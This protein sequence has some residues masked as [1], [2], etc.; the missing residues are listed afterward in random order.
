MKKDIV[1]IGAGAAGLICAYKLAKNTN[2]NI[3]VIEKES[4]PGK[5]LKAA[6]S[7]KCNIT[8]DLYSDT[9]Y[10]SKELELLKPYILKH[11]KQD[12]LDLFDELMLPYYEQ[13]GYYYPISN[14]GK[15]V[16]STL[17]NRCLEL[18]VQFSF[19]TLALKIQLENDQYLIKCQ[20]KDNSFDVQCEYLVCAMGGA[21]SKQLGGTDKGYKLLNDIGYSY[22]D[23]LPALAPIY[24]KDSNLKL[25]KG[26]RVNGT[27]SIKNS[28]DESIK[29]AGQIQFNEDCISGICVM[30]LSGTMNTWLK[31]NI[32]KEM[33]LDIVPQYS[34]NEL[35]N[36]F[37]AYQKSYKNEKMLDCLNT[38]LPNG[39]SKYILARIKI[40]DEQLLGELTDKTIN[41]LTSTLKKLELEVIYKEEFNKAQV[42]QGGICLNQ[43]S[44]E[45][46]ESKKH[47]KLYILGEL[48]DVNGDCGGYNITFAFLSAID[49]A[50]HVALH[51]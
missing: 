33:F 39:I 42:S 43:I 3:I 7:G 22:T 1:I 14:Q 32:Y 48:L 11:S 47:P 9:V 24:V 2:K 49:A 17:Y 31:E 45:T 16:V 51:N 37:I 21:A 15:Q 19:S 13:N 5:K 50:K 26:V 35:K 29:E 27:I 25:A 4:L 40:K 44:L 10:H 20:D 18:G 34:W 28:H 41:K 30:N 8:N 36:Y 38:F 46:F 6:G 23:I 12:I